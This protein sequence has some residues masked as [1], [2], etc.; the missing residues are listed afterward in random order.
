[1]YQDINLEC[2]RQSARV[3][4]SDDSTALSSTTKTLKGLNMFEAMCLKGTIWHAFEDPERSM[5]LE[6]PQEKKLEHEHTVFDH[7]HLSMSY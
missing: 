1:M 4:E 7:D 2:V 5:S 6:Q 3:S